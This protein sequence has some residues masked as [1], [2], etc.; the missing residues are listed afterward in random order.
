MKFKLML[1][2]WLAVAGFAHAS[3]EL[4]AKQWLDKLAHAVHQRNFEASYV[5]VKGNVMEPYRW[6]HGVTAQGEVEQL[7]YLN[8]GGA[9]I[10]R[11]GDH[12]TYFE[13]NTPPYTL[14]TSA[15]T[16]PIPE[17]LFGDISQLEQHYQFV[18]GGQG[19]IA[20]R[21]AQLVRIEAKDKQK[22]NYLV[23][24]DVDSSLLLK[25][26]YINPQGQLV[27]QLQLMHINVTEKPLPVL[28]KLTEQP[29]PKPLATNRNEETQSAPNW[30]INWLPQGFELLKATRK[31]LTRNKE[32]ADYYL[33]SDGFVEVSVF[34]QRPLSG[35]RNGGA[36]SSGATTVYIHHGGEFDV[37]VVGNIPAAT[38]KRIAESVERPSS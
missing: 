38:A 29:L 18:L 37:S 5:V 15:I 16:G 21:L 24:I 6:R 8:E 33:Y 28:V 23:W 26:A 12:V 34:I 19:R 9:E 4:T 13:P 36:L 1:L 11:I 30:Q 25:A 3:V 31:K 27:E 35:Q 17:V 2:V 10:V 20:D 32:L 14:K 22:L 7:S